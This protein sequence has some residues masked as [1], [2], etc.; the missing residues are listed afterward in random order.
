MDWMKREIGDTWSKGLVPYFEEY[1][2]KGE[3]CGQI[4]NNEAL[5]Q[6]MGRYDMYKYRSENDTAP[7]LVLERKSNDLAERKALNATLMRKLDMFMRQTN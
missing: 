1:V 4:Q 6:R 5:A 7:L 3:D 2:A